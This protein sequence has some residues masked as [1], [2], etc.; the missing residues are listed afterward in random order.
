MYGNTRGGNV[1]VADRVL[2]HYP[3]IACLT[4][5]GKQIKTEQTPNNVFLSNYLYLKQNG[6]F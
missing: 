5:P 6:L 3:E 4:L 1:F 2:A